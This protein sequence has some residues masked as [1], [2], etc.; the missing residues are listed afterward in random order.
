M[1]RTFH[2]RELGGLLL[3]TA[4]LLCVVPLWSAGRV[5]A[6]S[7]AFARP[8]LEDGL[9]V[10]EV[11][12]PPAEHQR[13]AV[14]MGQQALERGDVEGARAIAEEA[15]SQGNP[16]ALHT[17][18]EVLLQQGNY[19]EAV[20][21]WTQA[22]DYIS[23]LDLATVSVNARDAAVTNTAYQGLLQVNPQETVWIY[24]ESLA[25]DMD[26]YAA[27]ELLLNE[28]IQRFA[29][30]DISTQWVYRLGQLYSE[31]NR[32]DE[33]AQMF[34]KV[35]TYD[36]DN[37]Q[38]L[39]N[40]GNI[41]YYRG[42]GVKQASEW[43]QQAIEL[44]PHK[45]DAYHAFALIL[46]RE[47]QYQEADLW[48]C[49]ALTVEPDG[50]WW[51]I[52]WA[53]NARS[54]GDYYLAIHRYQETLALFPN[55]AQ[56]Y[57]ELAW[58]YKLLNDKAEAR[59]NIVTALDLMEIPSISYYLRAA[60]IYEWEDNNKLALEMYYKALLLDPQN[61]IAQDAIQR[62]ENNSE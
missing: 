58:N 18:G 27:A 8:A 3:A 30:S 42:D 22:F 37:Y 12:T 7:L 43:F 11:P 57:Y 19:A 25:H 28:Y 5:N 10:P 45:G 32:W 56:V 35:L 15:A 9:A 17:L 60:Q 33:A 4:L 59:Q 26:D 2:R 31:E 46:A 34:K 41:A 52:A 13:G 38:A 49:T 29:P 62:L 40:L 14:W 44:I 21:A 16:L 50:R 61:S 53:N 6:W 47:H 39:I 55:W 48:Y 23:L 54:M 51:W 1:E 24:A 20:D 36:P